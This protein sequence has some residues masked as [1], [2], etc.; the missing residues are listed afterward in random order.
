MT[1][2]GRQIQQSKGNPLILIGFT[3]LAILV[4]PPFIYSVGPKGPVKKGNVVFSTGQYRA[5][6][7]NKTQYQSLGY[8]GFCML[9]ARDQL[10]VL[11]SEAARGDGTYL[12][13]KIGTRE[14][15]FPDCPSQSKVILYGNQITLKPDMWGGIQDT[16]IWF[17]P[18]E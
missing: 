15:I 16:L 2:S 4:I 12:M 18:F 1:S 5:Y 6:F 9:Q 10:L 7:P 17:F 14:R 11:E 8:D 13:Q 3:I